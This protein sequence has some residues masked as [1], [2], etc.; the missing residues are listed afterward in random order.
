[1]MVTP[2]QTK[3]LLLILLDYTLLYTMDMERGSS[4]YKVSTI[5]YV[6]RLANCR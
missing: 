4:I 3:K 1:M 2:R 6:C 5:Y